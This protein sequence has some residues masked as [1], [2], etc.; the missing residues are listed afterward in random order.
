MRGGYSKE[1]ENLRSQLLNFASL[2]ELELDFSE[3]D[4]EF[5]DRNELNNLLDEI[6]LK[7][8]SLID[9]FSYGRY[10]KWSACCYYRKTKFWKVVPFK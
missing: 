1:I 10:K 2:I 6:E 3:E 7:L 5:A 9:S 4:V 8:E